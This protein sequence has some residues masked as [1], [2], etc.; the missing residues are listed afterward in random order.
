MRVAVNE[1][2]KAME[3]SEIKVPLLSHEEGKDKKEDKGKGDET[4]K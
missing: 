1:V 3:K 4:K 2:E